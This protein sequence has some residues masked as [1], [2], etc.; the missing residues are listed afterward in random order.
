MAGTC[1]KGSVCGWT[2]NTQK[3]KI[4]ANRSSA[5]FYALQW[6]SRLL[7]IIRPLFTFS[8]YDFSFLYIMY[9]WDYEQ[10]RIHDFFFFFW[11]QKNT[12]TKSLIMKIK[13]LL[14]V[15]KTQ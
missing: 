12:T 14:N 5:G 8:L 15:K 6:T 9:A 2:K 13:Q 11:E 7:Q 3:V 10:W 1:T 4:K